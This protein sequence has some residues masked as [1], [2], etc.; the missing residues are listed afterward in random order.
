MS[1]KRIIIVTL[2]IVNI[3]ASL[4]FFAAWLIYID[5]IISGHVDNFQN[6]NIII[7]WII[8]LLTIVILIVNIL[9]L[10]DYFKNREIKLPIS[11]ISFLFYIII[12]SLMISNSYYYNQ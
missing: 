12:F 3:L 5:E 9:I 8:P 11:L 10:V 4:F 1:P 7:D 2:S 6:N